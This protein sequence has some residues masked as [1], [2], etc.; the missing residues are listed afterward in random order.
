MQKAI[1]SA[2]RGGFLHSAQDVSDGGVFIALA[3]SALVKNFGFNI[4]TISGF[5]KD[6]FLFGEAQGRAIVSVSPS[7]AN[8]FEMLMEGK[9]VHCNFL[10]KV[11]AQDFIVDGEQ[12]LS[13]NEATDLYYNSLERL[14]FPAN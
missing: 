5:R 12:Y 10:G 8:E 3:D 4:N 11:T 14:L 2:I 7:R 9:N 13:S 6:A 1:Q